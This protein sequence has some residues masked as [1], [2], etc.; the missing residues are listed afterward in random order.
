VAFIEHSLAWGNRGSVVVVDSGGRRR[1]LT[2]EWSDLESLAWGVRE[3]EVWFT[4]FAPGQSKAGEIQAVSLS[5]RRRLVASGAGP[6]GL[7][8]VARD[9]R[10]LVTRYTVRS[11]ILGLPPGELAERELSWLDSSQARDLSADGRTLLF[12]ESSEGAASGNYDVYIRKTDG[13][14]AVRIGERAARAVAGREVGP[15]GHRNQ[16]STARHAADGRR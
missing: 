8:D 6:M 12:Y 4:G 9:G 13:S 7:E 10:A 2:D 14:P 16:S 3:D 15:F 5:G 11:G 1:P